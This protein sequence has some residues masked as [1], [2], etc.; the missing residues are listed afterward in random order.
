MFQTY[1]QQCFRA[2]GLS[3]QAAAELEELL[4]VLGVCGL[5]ADDIAD[6]VERYAAHR[7]NVAHL[8]PK[9]QLDVPGQL[10]W[11]EVVPRARWE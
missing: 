7:R 2:W 3:P 1:A 6:Q 9:G 10:T 4:D 11:F 8:Q 5:G